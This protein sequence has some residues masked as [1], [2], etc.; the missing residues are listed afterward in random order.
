MTRP[1]RTSSRLASKTSARNAS[2]TCASPGPR[3]DG[4]QLGQN[5]SDG[6]GLGRATAEAEVEVPEERVQLSINGRRGVI[7]FDRE[8]ARHQSVLCLGN[9]F[10]GTRGKESED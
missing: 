2:N 7:G 8:I 4:S 10:E 1:R 3:G 6:G 5:L 9:G